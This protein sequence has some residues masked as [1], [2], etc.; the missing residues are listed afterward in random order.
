MGLECAATK[1][2]N[3]GPLSSRGNCN[4]SRPSLVSIWLWPENVMINNYEVGTLSKGIK[5]QT[6]AFYWPPPINRGSPVLFSLCPVPA[7]AAVIKQAVSVANVKVGV[8]VR[9][10]R[11]LLIPHQ[12]P[13]TWSCAVFVTFKLINRG[14]EWSINLCVWPV[15]VAGESL[16]LRKEFNRHSCC[17]EYDFEWPEEMCVA[18][19]WDLLRRRFPYYLHC[20]YKGRSGGRKG[21]IIWMIRVLVPEYREWPAE[22]PAYPPLA[23]VVVEFQFVNLKDWLENV[24][25]EWILADALCRWLPLKEHLRA[26]GGRRN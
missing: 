6:I 12:S 11:P 1:W 8:S 18:V 7:A 17:V 25:G 10:S 4:R 5:W 16:P 21:W 24:C 26:D 9:S 15:V 19:T 14:G 23:S 2:I 20:K 3:K 22:W 13:P